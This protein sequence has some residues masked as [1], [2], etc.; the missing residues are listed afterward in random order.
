MIQKSDGAR[1]NRTNRA[2]DPILFIAVRIILGVGAAGNLSI[3][4]LP[5]APSAASS[6]PS[7][8]PAD[9]LLSILADDDFDAR[10]PAVA[11][12]LK[13]GSA[14]ACLRLGRFGTNRNERV[15][16]HAVRA[17]AVAGCRDFASL[18]PFLDDPSPWVT[19]AVLRE[20]ERQKRREAVPYLIDRL[21]DRRA[22]VSGDGS[23]TIAESAHRALRAL[24]CQSFHFDPAGSPAGQAG[25]RDRF[26]AWYAEHGGEPREKWIASGLSSARD[27]LG[28]DL[29]ATRREGL[30]LLL[31]IGS[32][33]AADL[34]AALGRKPGE[35][36]ASLTCDPTE[37]PRVSDRVPCSLLVT[38]ASGRTIPLV[39]IGEGPEVRL[40]RQEEGRMETR[41]DR[42]REAS[43]ESA[44]TSDL[45]P[46]ILQL[47]PG[48]VLRREFQ[49]GPV[50]AA[51]H[52]E[53]RA[54]LLD[55]AT[56]LPA[57]DAPAPAPSVTP[58]TPRGAKS[59]AARDR[60]LRPI[61][62]PGPPS[63]QTG[64]PAID[65]STILRFEQ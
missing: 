35:L 48:D 60:T 53:V 36:R 49:V 29:A 1:P 42:P 54:T 47:G 39:P 51:G 25:A 38:N 57:P 32:P 24:T 19:E 41:A 55:L 9:P 26:R 21:T 22:I 65:A 31:M 62:A 12:E 30:E 34:R 6:A 45:A 40:I 52:Y 15:R 23:W 20:I 61:E 7:P 14:D 43:Q 27:D 8:A 13:Q 4:T 44:T 46:R 63:R 2:G 10:A 11:L 28:S 33:A 3:A 16:E 17:L 56:T 64:P 58:V 59:P 37:P 5:G 18:D 50:R